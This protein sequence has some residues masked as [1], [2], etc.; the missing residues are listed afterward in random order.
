MSADGAPPTWLVCKFK[1]GKL[2]RLEPTLITGGYEFLLASGPRPGVPR[3]TFLNFCFIRVTKSRV[4]RVVEELKE[5]DI[6]PLI[7]PLKH[8][9]SIERTDSDGP[10]IEII[11]MVI[12]DSE[13]EPIRSWLRDVE[14]GRVETPIKPGDEVEIKI[15]CFDGRRGRVLEVKGGRVFT[16]VELMGRMVPVNVPMSDVVLVVGEE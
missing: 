7:R 13:L 5:P 12:Q 10:D 3:A 6:K 14:E 16:E 15:A 1:R 2:A 9:R 8:H 4:D 11:P